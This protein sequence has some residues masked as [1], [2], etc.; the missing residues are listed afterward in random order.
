MKPIVIF[1][2]LFSLSL[3]LPGQGHAGNWGQWRGPHFDG[4][5]DETS[6]PTVFSKT[7]AVKWAADLPGPSA[8]TPAVWGQNVFISSSE[9]KSKTLHAL[10]LDRS[11]G[12]ILWNHEVAPGLNQDDKS[13]FA[14]PS[15]ATDGK[16]AVFLYGNG[17]VA[18]YD[19][20]GKKLWS[21][22]L[23]KDYGP[24]A[25]QW[26]YG[27]SPVLFGGKLFIQ[28]LHRN[29]PVRGRGKASNE[30]YILALEPASGKELW[31]HIRDS[32]ARMESQEAYSTPIPYQNGDRTE[33]LIAGGDCI[34]GHKVSDGEE[35]WRWGTWNPN[36]I[37]HWRLVASPVSGAGI[38]LACA[39]KTAPIYALK[40]G[41]K[42]KQDDSVLAWK[43]SELELSSDVATPLYYKGRFYV[44]NG[45]RRTITRVD[46]ATGKPDWI[47]DLD[48]RIKIES[49]PTA[50]DDKIYFQNFRGEVFVVG[51]QKDFKLI[52][53][54]PMGDEGDDQLR[55][56][57]ALSDGELFLRTG[58]K[59]YC[60]GK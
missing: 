28:V 19:I 49:S 3:I 14:S 21:R 32:E 12:K 58:R 35:L 47:G 46:P 31:R 4:S 22:N 50:G 55:S 23:E 52:A 9:E 40:S 20:A 33:L 54:I 56:S 39:P 37:T 7:N 16:L 15:P 36:R 42:G 25:Y 8:A 11:S 29:E 51:A 18:A 34:S 27:A 10:C 48:S 13:N 60:V 59:L 1:A 5:S 24:F 38:I 17:P 45:E 44:V 57:V 30:S 26:T 2:L 6:L 53:K 43:S 41:A